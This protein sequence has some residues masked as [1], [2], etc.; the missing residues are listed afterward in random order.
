M[1]DH[2]R[3]ELEFAIRHNDLDHEDIDQVGKI[4]LNGTTNVYTGLA[5][6]AF[7]FGDG[8]LRPFVGAGI[9]VARFEVDIDITDPVE[10]SRAEH[11]CRRI[12]GDTDYAISTN[13][14]LFAEGEALMIDDVSLDPASTGS[15]SLSNPLFLSTSLGLRYRF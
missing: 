3:A 14:E 15:A 1:V 10:A 5:K 9:G 13:A 7:D 4:D 11:L 2:L 6:I 12:L 8:P